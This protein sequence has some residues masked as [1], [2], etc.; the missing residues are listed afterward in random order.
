MEERIKFYYNSQID[1]PGCNLKHVQQKLEKLS[2]AG[3]PVTMIDTAK[4]EDEQLYKDYMEA[5]YPSVRKQYRIRQIFGSQNKSGQFFGRQQPALVVYQEE[6]SHPVDVYPHDENGVR[7]RIEDFLD[8]KSQELKI[9][10]ETPVKT[11]EVLDTLTCSVEGVSGKYADLRL[12]SQE[13]D[14]EH[15]RCVQYPLEHLKRDFGEVTE[16]MFLRCEIRQFDEE[17]LAFHFEK[18]TPKVFSLEERQVLLERYKGLSS[19]T[20]C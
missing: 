16:G 5:T 19:Q 10:G 7:V 20:I 12:R 4:M 3:I 15:D 8:Q 14:D 1:P 13:E 17:N 9:A 18:S 6:D 2:D 11:Y